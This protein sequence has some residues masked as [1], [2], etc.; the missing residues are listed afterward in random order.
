[1]QPSPN[2]CIYVCVCVHLFSAVRVCSVLINMQIQLQ[3]QFMLDII[4]NNKN[5]GKNINKNKAGQVHCCP[6]QCMQLNI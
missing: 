6:F 2:L 3:C 1:M 4:Y 5:G